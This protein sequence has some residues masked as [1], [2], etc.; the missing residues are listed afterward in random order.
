MS[1]N[2]T[3]A[4]TRHKIKTYSIELIELSNKN[5]DIE[6]FNELYEEIQKL[7]E[8]VDSIEMKYEQC[9]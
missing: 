8:L 1:I 4:D 2:K 9:S 3:L 5:H 7:K 6:R